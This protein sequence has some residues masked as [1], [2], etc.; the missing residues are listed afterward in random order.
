VKQAGVNIESQLFKR[1]AAK[2]YGLGG[3]QWEAK[4]ISS[5]GSI[6]QKNAAAFYGVEAPR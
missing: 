6:F 2:F 5:Q 4:S 3:D 1:N